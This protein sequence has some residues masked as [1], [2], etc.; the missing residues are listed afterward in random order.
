MQSHRMCRSQFSLIVGLTVARR[1]IT[2]TAMVSAVPEHIREEW[3]KAN[4]LGRLASP[5]EM[6]NV[7]AFLLS[8]KSSFITSAVRL[9]PSHHLLAHLRWVLTVLRSSMLTQVAFSA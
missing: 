8:E 9:E 2:D 4:V 5:V 1:G 6:A 3:R 7:I